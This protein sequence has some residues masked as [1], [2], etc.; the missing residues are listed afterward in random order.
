MAGPWTVSRDRRN[1]DSGTDLRAALGRLGA[2]RRSAPFVR[3]TWHRSRSAVAHVRL[4]S[5]ATHWPPA[6]TPE[7]PPAVTAKGPSAGTAR[8]PSA[9]TAGNPSAGGTC[10]PATARLSARWAIPLLALMS[11]AAVLIA[12]ATA[13]IA[14]RAVTTSQAAAR[15]VGGPLVIP[16]PRIAGAYPRRFG[17][18]TDPAVLA[19]VSQ[20]RQRFEAV[21]TG[22]LADARRAAETRNPVGA[23]SAAGATAGGNG[24]ADRQ[25]TAAWTSGLY[26]EPGHLDPATYRPSWVMYLGLD[27]S[28]MLGRPSTTI[29]RLMTG[30]LGPAAV[31]GPWRVTPGHRGGSAN[32]TVAWLGQTSVSVCGWATDHTIGA[33]VS[34]VRDTSVAELATMMIKM[35]F[36]L[37]RA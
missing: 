14:E 18:I 17:A 3:Q 12:L 4:G 33:L 28:G 22:L 9:G 23:G 25:V 27:A 6:V 20:F 10:R 26:G 35:R 21:G 24:A 2:L 36:D 13:H 5:V 34:P 16:A 31:V 8:N 30:L 15:K 32:C 11:V 29:A 37:Q 1:G 7:R 19:I